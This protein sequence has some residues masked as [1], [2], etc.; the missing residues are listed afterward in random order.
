MAQ[1]SP[2]R[3]TLEIIQSSLQ[4]AAVIEWLLRK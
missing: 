1:T 3:I 4:A 2:D